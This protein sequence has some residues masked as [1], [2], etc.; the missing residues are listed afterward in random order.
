[1]TVERVVLYRSLS[2]QPAEKPVSHYVPVGDF[3]VKL[4]DSRPDF[5]HIVLLRRAAAVPVDVPKRGVE[6]NQRAL[7]RLVPLAGTVYYDTADLR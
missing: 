6:E 7:A 4:I 5:D 3:M 1:M 2:P